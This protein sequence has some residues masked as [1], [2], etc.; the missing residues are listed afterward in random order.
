[1]SLPI[2]FIVLSYEWP[3]PTLVSLEDPV[4]SSSQ[5]PRLY[6]I[7]SSFWSHHIIILIYWYLLAFTFM[8][9]T[10]G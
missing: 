4:T 6:P 3:L 1:M 5:G 7:L 9:P 8:I 10:F 2:L